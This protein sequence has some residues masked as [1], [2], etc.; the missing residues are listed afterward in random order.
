MYIMTLY[1]NM[2]KLIINHFQYGCHVYHLENLVV[3]SAE[4]NITDAFISVYG[5]NLS[6]QLYVHNDTQFTYN[7]LV[8][9]WAY[10][11]MN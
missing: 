2:G 5:Y 6:E 9:F 7:Y 10:I 3:N 8:I 11:S 1:E 4:T